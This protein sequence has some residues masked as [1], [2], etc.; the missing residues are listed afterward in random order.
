MEDGH[1]NLTYQSDF[2]IIPFGS[3]RRGCPGASMAIPTIELA[4]G[5]LLRTFDWRVEGESSQLD[6]K[7]AC[8]ATILRQVPLCSY[9]RLR[10]NFPL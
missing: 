9:L 10:V 3:G 8:G 2:S 7:E 6:M 4:L 1:I 5:Q